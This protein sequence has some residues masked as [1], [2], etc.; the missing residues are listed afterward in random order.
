MVKTIH[1]GAIPLGHCQGHGDGRT[2]LYGFVYVS[3]LGQNAGQRSGGGLVPGI[4]TDVQEPLGL[5]LV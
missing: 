5:G 1:G 2:L 3:T 4:S